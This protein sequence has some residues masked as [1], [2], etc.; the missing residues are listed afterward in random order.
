MTFYSEVVAPDL[1]ENSGF[2]EQSFFQTIYACFTADE[3]IFQPQSRKRSLHTQR[4]SAMTSLS[5][6]A[7]DAGAAVWLHGVGARSTSSC[8]GDRA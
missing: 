7:N 4:C 3:D 2:E 8:T 1:Q 6:N 5:F